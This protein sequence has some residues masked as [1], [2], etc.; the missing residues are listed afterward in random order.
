MEPPL[1]EQKPVVRWA[2]IDGLGREVAIPRGWLGDFGELADYV[3]ASRSVLDGNVGFHWIGRGD[4]LYRVD[5]LVDAAAGQ[6]APYVEVTVS[7]VL[8]P[9]KLTVRELQVLTL[10]AGGLTNPDI[11]QRLGTTR[12]TVATHLEHV[13]AKLDAPTRTAAAALALSAHLAV[14][15]IPGGPHGLAPID[16]QQLEN[17]MRDTGR[18]VRGQRALP[19]LHKQPVL[20]G[21]IYPLHGPAAADGKGRRQA[22]EMAIAEVNSQGGIVDRSVEHVP[23]EF[24]I[25]DRSS[26]TRAISMLVEREVDAI[27]FGYTLA[28][29]DFRTA[30]GKAADYGCPVLHSATSATAHRTVFDEPDRFGNVFQVCAQESRYGLGFVR[31]LNELAESGT[32]Q[33]TSRRLLVIDSSDPNLTTFTTEA[34]VAADRSG[35]QATVVE[36]DFIRPD[37]K[38]VLA[39]LGECEPAAVMVATWVEESLQEFLRAFRAAGLPSLIYAIYAPSVPGFLQRAGHL[40]EGLLWATVIG[41]YDD[42][43]GEQFA[44]RFSVTQHSDPGRSGAAI[45]YDMVH[46]LSQAWR[47][48][49]SPRDYAAVTTRMRQVVHRGVSGIYYFGTRG[50]SALTYPDD[51]R[52][53]SL[54]QAHLVHQ[55][56]SGRHVIVAPTSHQQGFVQPPPWLP[57]QALSHWRRG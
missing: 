46:L 55:I 2:R 24:D 39:R 10:V 31:F 6:P 41:L 42:A 36:V 4:V 20:V 17:A 33:P 3:R 53:P 9:F 29:D 51:T 50:Q 30:L 25:A 8:A 49:P 21:G 35:W 1:V 15:P 47:A 48:A 45:H 22:T 7:P 54:G 26:L 18:H 38:P 40:A 27:T 43:L 23:V 34:A 57:S 13:L 16:V 32:W 11:A 19:V 12:R 56:Q 28:R 14:L 37:W 52:D 44:Q 5:L